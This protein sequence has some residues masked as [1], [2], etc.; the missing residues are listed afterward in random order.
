MIWRR[1]LIFRV[2]FRPRGG[3]RALEDE[4]GLIGVRRTR[5]LRSR[6]WNLGIFCLG[7]TLR[8]Y[9]GVNNRAAAAY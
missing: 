7:F 6:F 4:D 8:T 3:V 5:V 9:P 2:C 1:G